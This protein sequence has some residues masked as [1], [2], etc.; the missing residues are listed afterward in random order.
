M[1]KKHK[2]SDTFYY[3]AKTATELLHI[4]A[5]LGAN[6]VYNFQKR[7]SPCL[8]GKAAAVFSLIIIIIIISPVLNLLFSFS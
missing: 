2:G 7:Q 5:I 4:E 3:Y 8:Q 1:I 6:G